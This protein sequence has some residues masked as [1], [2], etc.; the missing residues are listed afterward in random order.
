MRVSASPIFDFAIRTTVLHATVIPIRV[1]RN[2]HEGAH[3]FASFGAPSLDRSAA[4]D[5]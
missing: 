3:V 5:R 2:S 4:A 1:A